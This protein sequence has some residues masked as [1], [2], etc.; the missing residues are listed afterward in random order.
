V[1]WLGVAAAV[2]TAGSL[3]AQTEPCSIR[4]QVVD[5]TGAGVT[6]E[7]R[8]KPK[9]SSDTIHRGRT[10]R[11][12]NLCVPKIN[13]GT[14]TLVLFARGFQVRRVRDVMVNSGETLDLRSVRVDIGDCDAPGITCDSLEPERDIVAGGGLTLP[15]GCGLNLDKLD[16]ICSTANSS[17]DVDLIFTGGGETLFLNPQNG[18]RIRPDCQKIGFTDEPLR[19]DGMGSGDNFCVRTKKGQNSHIYFD[20][21]DVDKS[22]KELGLWITTR[23]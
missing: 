20:A 14:Y 5:S 7:V 9:D 13:P 8:V 12:G 1:R 3:A 10:D 15:R 11:D 21:V 18:A 17:R 6:A 19:L 4:L 23:K 22:T 2:V 16:V